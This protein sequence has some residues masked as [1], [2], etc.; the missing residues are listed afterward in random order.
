[1]DDVNNVPVEGDEVVAPE[2]PAAEPTEGAAD[3]A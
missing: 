3:A 2:A 1:M